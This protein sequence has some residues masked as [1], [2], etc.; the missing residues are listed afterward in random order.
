MCRKD[1]DAKMKRNLIMKELYKY[2]DVCLIDE[3][4]EGNFEDGYSLDIDSLPKNEISNF[5]DRLMQEDTTI[6]D[7]VLSHMQQMINERLPIREVD[8]R[9]DRQG[10][11]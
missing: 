8:Y 3:Y 7:F 11:A 4:A 9:F 10:A 6:R 1:Y 5:L 2:I